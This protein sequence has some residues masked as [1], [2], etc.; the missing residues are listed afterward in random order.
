MG[1][2]KLSIF[3]HQVMKIYRPAA[4]SW[5]HAFLFGFNDSSLSLKPNKPYSFGLLTVS[6][7]EIVATSQLV[8]ILTSMHIILS[9]VAYADM[10]RA[11]FE[12][13]CLLIFSEKSIFTVSML[14]I[15]IHA[16]KLPISSPV[17]KSYC[18]LYFSRALQLLRVSLVYDLCLSKSSSIS[19][20]FIDQSCVCGL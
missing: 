19:L 6:R 13:A 20:T 14:G 4:W 7:D 2:T 16:G 8:I 10:L 5:L 18:A 1:S 12:R 17:Y 3:L 15:V 11:C 9:Y